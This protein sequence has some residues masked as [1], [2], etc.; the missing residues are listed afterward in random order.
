MAEDSP[1]IVDAEWLEKRL[2]TPGVT[3]IDASWYLPAQKRDARAEYDAAHIPGALFLDQDAVSD[4][5]S[6][7]PHTLASPQ[8]FA[9]YVGSMGVSAD[10]TIVVYDGPGF[11]SAPRA[12]WMF[13]VMGVFQVYILNG[14]FDRWKAEGRPVTAERTRIA[15]CV[16]YADFDASRVV[17]L[18]EMRRIVG[19]GESQIA[20]AR[21][22]GRFAGTDPEPRPGVRSGHMP[23]ARNVP[24]AA[25]AENG[26]LLSRDSLRKVIEDAGID[27]SKPVVTSCGSGITAAAIT[28]ALETLGHTDNRLYDGSWTEWGGLSDT[29]V[30]TGK[31]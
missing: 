22:P 24:I 12:W 27:L 7:L 25:L 6:K 9:Q 29:P 23:G 20:D 1:F 8:Y 2:G 30:V 5:D 4:P 15:P 11:F 28:L 31:E 19:S 3:I 10:D 14:G 26:E 17:S 16:F 13:R 18:D 21:S